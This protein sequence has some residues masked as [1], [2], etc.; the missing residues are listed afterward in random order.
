MATHRS[1]KRAP[2]FLPPIRVIQ[3]LT[4]AA[5]CLSSARWATRQGRPESIFAHSAD[6]QLAAPAVEGRRR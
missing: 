4:F 3:V 1:S 2:R 6:A 5:Q